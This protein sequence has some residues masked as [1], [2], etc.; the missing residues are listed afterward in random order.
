MNSIEELVNNSN[1][2]MIKQKKEWLEIFSGFETKNTYYIYNSNDDHIGIISE[3]GKGILNILSRLFLK[4]HRPFKFKIT[5]TKG[6]ELLKVKR[7]FFWF[8]SDLYVRFRGRKFGSIHRR[9]SFLHKTYSILDHRGRE[10]FQIKSPI[11]RLWTFPIF[12]KRERTVGVITKRWQ[13]LI[14]EVFTDADAFYID[15]AS[16]QLTTEEKVLLFVSG[17]SIDFDFFEENQG[18]KSILNILGK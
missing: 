8:F 12:D 17:I 2:F 10:I 3:V 18:R 15:L 7:T 5:N 14:S 1:Q 6:V 16:K 11:W 4:S 9:F 13:G